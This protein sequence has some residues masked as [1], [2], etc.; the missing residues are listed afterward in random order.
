ML[1]F[2]CGDSQ[3]VEIKVKY[4]WKPKTCLGCKVFGHVYAHYPYQTTKIPEKVFLPKYNASQSLSSSYLEELRQNPLQ[5]IS[6]GP[7]F[8]KSIMH[9]SPS[10]SFQSNLSFASAQTKHHP[11]PVQT[12]ITHTNSTQSF[13]T[14]AKNV[15]T[16]NSFSLLVNDDIEVESSVASLAN[17][18]L[19][20]VDIEIEPTTAIPDMTNWPSKLK[21]KNI[22]YVPIALFRKAS[23]SQSNSKKKK[24]Q[25]KLAIVGNVSTQ[26]CNTSNPNV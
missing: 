9:S 13:A 4:Q 8:A 16:N 5:L 3:L 6:F 26:A 17:S 1:R 12:K 11:F 7:T 24:K 23:G 21:D 15:E 25:S 20:N 2:R 18:I 10:T 22:D 14:V 19:V